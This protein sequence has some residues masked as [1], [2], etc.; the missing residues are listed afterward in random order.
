MSGRKSQK[1][2]IYRA[3]CRPPI[4][5]MLVGLML[6]GACKSEKV[7]DPKP[8][9]PSTAPSTA[10]LA[11]D[12]PDPDGLAEVENPES[13]PPERRAIQFVHG[14][15]RVV[16]TQ[17]ALEKGLTIVDLTDAWAPRI[18]QDAVDAEGKPLINRYRQ[19]FVGMANDKTDGDGQP[20]EPG[21]K[22]YLELLGIPPSLSVLR[23]RFLD[24]EK[25]DCSAVNLELVR[26]V[27]RVT[28][29]SE[30]SQKDADATQLARRKRL[31]KAMATAG[32]ADLAALVVAESK[33]ERDVK[34]A[35]KQ[36]AERAAFVEVEKRM[37]CEGR[38]DAA[39]H[40]AGI[41]D[42]VMASAVVA[43]QMENMLLDLTE[44]QRST[45]ETM[46]RSPQANNFE[47]LRRTIRERVVRAGGILEDGSADPGPGK[48][49]K[50]R[51]PRYTTR[52]GEG[53][54]VP[55]L[56]EDALTATMVR[57]GIG[58]P[59]D[60]VAFFKR[61][62]SGDFSWLKVAVRFPEVPEYYSAHMDFEAEVDRGDVWYEL[63]F[64]ANGNRLP[65]GRRILPSLT[66]FV[67]WQGKR[68]PLVKWRTTI[69]GWRTE[70]AP[71]GHDYLRYKGS[72]VGPRVWRHIVASPV[73]IPPEST[74][75]GGMIKK[76]YINGRRQWV[77]N[78]D[79]VGPGYLSAYGLAM[80][81]HVE[82]RK[83]SDGHMSYFDNG[84]RVHGSS[85][86]RSLRG[87]F[88]H[89]CHRL[90]NNLAVRLFDHLLA[91][92]THRIVGP[93]RLDFRRRFLREGRVFDMRLPVRGFYFELDPTIPVETLEGNIKG[94]L[95]K[96]IE[97]FVFK[98]GVEYPTTKPPPVPRGLA[99]KAGGGGD[100]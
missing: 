56:V 64:D 82:Q 39:K 86:Y 47:A 16:D 24:D 25:R 34:A 2:W 72:D 48:D 54:P 44:I 66:L 76:K 67:R 27:D 9:S 51:T 5:P 79:E 43:F 4:G 17:V 65:Q 57:L 13:L 95:K 90:Y 20:I 81:I 12:A 74:P 83:H 46:E 97:S 63:P 89:G 15:E 32:V 99:G 80:A 18:F 60:A 75:L 85:D 62:N 92:R 40:K 37:L 71:D 45:L 38:M 22:N 49:G 11:P 73:W 33:W 96:P 26:A 21:L 53:R 29:W 3:G 28:V 78:Y 30:R 91:H 100:V 59:E 68:I 35:Q 23:E 69:G 94:P 55:N 36:D 50:P 8:T 61:H 98:P 31:E 87:R 19:V 52:S 58:T 14:K 93:A 6:A 41:F 70:M 1:S 10:P 88:S 77:T 42:Q 84:I 7:A